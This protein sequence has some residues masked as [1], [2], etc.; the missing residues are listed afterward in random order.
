MILKKDN[1]EYTPRPASQR[2]HKES[3]DPRRHEGEGE[4]N[5]TF[6]EK[7]SKQQVLYGLRPV[8]EAIDAGKQ[9]DRIYLQSGASGNLMTELK[10][11]IR[12]HDIPFQFVPTEKLDKLTY[13]NHQGVVATIAL[14][15]YHALAQMLPTLTEESDAPFILMLDHLTDVR[16]VG[17]IVRTAECVGANAVVV[18]DHGSAQM[19]E[20]AVKTSSGALLRIPICRESNLKTAINLAKQY[21]LQVVAASEKATTD[22]LDTDFRLPTLLI[23]G[24]EDTGVSPELLR[25]CDHYA[26]LPIL[27]KVQ[28]LNVSAAAAVFMYELLRQRRAPSQD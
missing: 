20:D 5:Q 22:Y 4:D 14:I 13:A 11:K 9:I 16:N 15:P 19:N 25:L 21:G 8:I 7:H 1:S 28:S 6:R 18:P 10:E 26:K 17:A 2:P 12:E 27:G 3:R 24:A 23:M